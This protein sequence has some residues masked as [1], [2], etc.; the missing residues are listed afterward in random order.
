MAKIILGLGS[1][2]N[3]PYR[4]LKRAITHIAQTVNLTPKAVSGFYWSPPL[5]GGPTHQP[6]FINA[7]LI[8]YTSCSPKQLISQTQHIE[9]LANK[10]YL[11]H[12]G[13]RTLDIDLLLYDNLISHESSLTL[14]HPQMHK[15]WFCIYP[16]FELDPYTHFPD[17]TPL[18]EALKSTRPIPLK[19]ARRKMSFL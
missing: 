10:R 2:L 3:H 4:Q 13:P 11:C 15:R 9:R 7:V 16:F 6:A 17:G 19:R 1:N 18:K 14:P 8:A 5:A 12:W